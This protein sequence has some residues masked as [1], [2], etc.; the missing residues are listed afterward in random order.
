MLSELEKYLGKGRVRQNL[1]LAPF[2][3][4]KVG[5]PA[6]YYFEAETDEDLINA[7]KAVHALNIPLHI[8]GGISNVIIGPMGLKGL[9]VKNLVAY[10]KIVEDDGDHVILRVSSGYNMTRLAKETAEDGYGGLEYH[11]GL[12]GTVGG[13][14]CV[15]SGWYAHP[16]SKYVGDPVVRVCLIDK[17]GETRNEQ[18]GYFNFAYDYS[19][20]KDT[21]EIVIWV[22]FKLK[23][24]DP[25]AL[26]LHG[27]D[28]LNYRKK[29]QPF[30]IPSSGC[31]FQNLDGES[32][33]K[34]IDEAGL[35]GY[36]IG[37]AQVSTVHANFI[38]NT[39]NATAHDVQQL[40]E[41][42]KK[43]VKAKKGIDLEEEVICL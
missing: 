23:K 33:G 24:A 9:V 5:G 35:K 22:D 25:Q 27:Q 37:G 4:M 19:I 43:T 39:G 16:P 41:H 11:L 32:A 2:T 8:F 15:N 14:L 18:K 12:P 40:V 42:I 6:E 1:E 29:T 21:G 10:K 28:A 31:Y 3:T 13:G 20:L 38:V 7:V 34:I 30:G 36:T 17:N 26:I